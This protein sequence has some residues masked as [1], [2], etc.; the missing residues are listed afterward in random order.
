MV[1]FC[2]ISSETVWCHSRNICATEIVRVKTTPDY[3]SYSH[4]YELD[5]IAPPL[6][7]PPRVVEYRGTLLNLFG[8][9]QGTS[10]PS[11]VIVRKNAR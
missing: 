7:P 10:V 2:G 1:E 5:I 9:T 6:P 8:V 11:L 4:S 3:P